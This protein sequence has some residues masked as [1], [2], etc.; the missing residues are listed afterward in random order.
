MSRSLFINLGLFYGSPFTY[1]DLFSYVLVSFRTFR[2]LFQVSF[3]MSRSL[4]LAS[5]TGNLRIF[6]AR[7]FCCVSLHNPFFQVSFNVSRSLFM[8][9]GLFSQV[10]FHRSL[11]Q[12]SFHMSRSCY[13]YLDL[14]CWQTLHSIIDVGL[15]CESMFCVFFAHS[16]FPMCRS[17]F[18]YLGL[19]LQVS[20]HI[21]VSL[22][23]T[24][25]ISTFLVQKLFFHRSSFTYLCL[26]C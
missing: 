2:S 25:A 14:S 18:I 9:Q 7:L 15:F 13:T 16:P 5:T 8:C 24:S 12:V 21:S 20:L 26:F 17:L 19:F 11:F 1:L 23:M 22:L 4:M 10:S 6:C 3:H